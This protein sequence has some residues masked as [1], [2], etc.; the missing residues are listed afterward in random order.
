MISAILTPLRAR[1]ETSPRL[2][3]ATTLLQEPSPEDV[4]RDVLEQLMHNSVDKLKTV[5]DP[6]EKIEVLSEVHRIM[7]EDACTKAVF[8]ERDGFLAVVSALSSLAAPRDLVIVEPEEQVTAEILE[9]IRLVFVIASEAMHEDETNSSYF[10]RHVGYDSL[11]QALQPLLSKDTYR[12]QVLG[13]LFSLSLH[14]FS[15]SSIFMSLRDAKY[16][17]LDRRILQLEP[18]LGLI[19]QPNAMRL[20]LDL[21]PEISSDPVLHYVVYKL[22]ERLTA[23]SHRNKVVLSDLGLFRPLFRSFL[24]YKVDPAMPSQERRVM[25]KLLRRVLDLGASATDVRAIF[26][27]AINEDKSLNPHVL[28]LL[29]AGMKS[30]WTDHFSFERIA[31]IKF[32]EDGIRGLPSSGFTLLMW[33]LIERYPMRNT[34]SIFSFCSQSK[35]LF[36]IKLRTDGKLELWSSGHPQTPVIIKTPLVQAKWTHFTLVHRP[37]RGTENSLRLYIDGT[38]VELLNWAYPRYESAAQTCSYV[39]GEG[40]DDG[41][42]SWCMASATVLSKPLP[43]HFP[44]LIQH[45]G[46]RYD[47]AFQSRD[48]VRFL[49][50]E[51]ATGLNLFLSSLVG[52]VSS[53]EAGALVKA[54]NN[55]MDIEESAI[56]FSATP[57]IF[58]QPPKLHQLNTRFSKE[59]DVAYAQA[60]CIDS[61]MWQVGGVAVALKLVQLASTTHELSRTLG[62]LLDSLRA[63]WQNSEDM[64]RMRGYEILS[65]ILRKKSQLINVTAYETLFEFIGM[66]FRIPE[67]SIIQ[68]AVAYRAIA[69]D[70]ELWSRTREEI[71]RQHLEHFSTLL[72]LSRYKRFNVRQ[73]LSSMS[74]TKQLLFVWQTNWYPP[75]CLPYLQLAMQ[76]VIEATFTSDETIK[77]LISYLAANLYD[78]S[79]LPASPMSAIS[80]ID[81]M[82]KLDKAE[83]ILEVLVDLLSSLKERHRTFSVALP[84]TRICLLLL[85][86]NPSPVAA[87][88]AL[89]LISASIDFNFSFVRKFELVSGWTFLKSV[90]PSAWNANVQAAAFRVLL[91]RYWESKGGAIQPEIVCASIFPTILASLDRELPLAVSQVPSGAL[92]ADGSSS[93]DHETLCTSLMEVLIHLQATSPTFRELFKSQQ[94]TLACIQAFK[95]FV[96]ALQ[97]SGNMRA[98]LASVLD[99][100]KHFGLTLA[101]DNAVSGGHKRELLDLIETSETLVDNNQNGRT[102][103]DPELVAD[104]RSLARRLT[105]SRLSLQLGE[106]TM[107]KTMARINNWQATIVATEA[108]RLRKNLLDMQEDNRQ[109]ARLTE[110]DIPL[111]TERG[112]WEVPRARRLWQLDETEGPNRVRKRLEFTGQEQEGSKVDGTTSS[113]TVE[114]PMAEESNTLRMEVPPWAEAYEVST[115]DIAISEDRQLLEEVVEDKHRRIRHQLE[116]GDVIEAV[117]TITRITGVDSSPGLLIFGHTHLYVLDGLIEGEDGEII[118]A[119]DAPKRLFF[120]PG[121]II[122]IHES[123]RAQ[124]WSWSYDQI[125]NSS[126]RTFLFRNV[127]LEIYFRDSRSLLVAFLA[128]KQRGDMQQ[129]LSSILN[130]QTSVSSALRTPNPLRSPFVTRMMNSAKVFSTFREDG[131]LSAQRRWQTRELSNFAYLCILNQLSG[132]TPSDATQ[133]PVFPWVLQ[134]YV[135]EELDLSDRRV[136]RDLARPMGALTPARRDAAQSRYEALGSIGEKP[137]HYGTHFSSSMIVCHFLIRLAPFTNMFKTLQGGDWDLPD[138][139]DIGRSYSSAAY[140]IRGDVRELIPE[141]FMLPEFLENLDELD[142]GVQ[143]NTGERIHHVK[144]PPWAKGDPLLFIAMHRKA[145]ESD[146]VSENIHAWID[147]IWGYK[148]RDPESLNV[149]HPLSYEGSIDLDSITDELERE[150]TV[151]IIHNFGQTPRKLFSTPHPTRIMHG[152]STLPLGT[153]HGV[154]EDHALLKQSTKPTIRSLPRGTAVKS[155]V[156]DPISE[157]IIAHPAGVLSI[158][159]FPEEHIEW[160]FSRNGRF[161]AKEIRVVID[162]KVVQSVEGEDCTCAVFPDSENLVTGSRDFIVRLWRVSRSSHGSTRISLTHLMRVHSAEVVCVAASR[163]WSVVVSGS[164]D[165]SAVIWDLNRAKYIRSIWHGEGAEVHLVAINDS[166][167]YIATCSQG[168]LWL[169]TVNARP[170]AALDLAETGR[171]RGFLSPITSMA[172]LEREYSHLGILATATSDGKVTL[173]TWNADKTPKGEQAKWEFV[174][175]RELQAQKSSA[176]TALRF[177]GEDLF[178]GDSTGHTYRWSLPE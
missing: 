107:T 103:I 106:R 62:I 24:D 42:L 171:T 11:S 127:A 2:P 51:A 92:L 147:L 10:A 152:M 91:G 146:Y 98:G 59:G 116:P 118:D 97:T 69:L 43:E 47:S 46:P 81:T 40:S 142:F 53:N 148:Q 27:Y 124:R 22:L 136:F 173:R 14:D 52:R 166:T 163:P 155:L 83:R 36:S 90:I 112:L 67:S 60:R 141:F 8:R 134:D 138:R 63:S 168:K 149:F 28:D 93:V 123:R 72:V 143:Q 132:R 26:R 172:F 5:E 128:P 18:R 101:L 84:L 29:R 150:A 122:E 1:F 145:L 175:L 137:F 153:L 16:E 120:V 105:S 170:I 32:S 174:T 154:E 25:Q 37:H 41:E 131:L 68:N 156:P 164:S 125:A 129:R 135:S 6:R 162:G 158:P 12:D 38:L 78:T 115:A 4:A 159:S 74:V 3:Q 126:E 160:S 55:G 178:H 48:L 110:W 161:L 177:V 23:L 88:Q 94:T 65:S 45:L 56:V 76:S 89:N 95:S 7:L 57:A 99:K 144:L 77:P 66:N 111:T 86:N 140:D 61:A 157:R 73:R 35:T 58:N 96:N 39:F 117:S 30:K 49:T 114:V 82:H 113:R 31:T 104:R 85:G 17:D 108:K 44:R 70:F 169:H 87:Q 151:G 109:K 100:L 130:I 9:G 176:I 133:Y 34:Q 64:E 79:T 71:Q 15:V 20:L 54:I 167:G 33:L 119:A 21:L 19:A 75:E 13:F 80:A 102:S 50:Y 139:F 165:G 121:S